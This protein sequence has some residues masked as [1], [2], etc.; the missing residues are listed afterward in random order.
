M[1]GSAL[2]WGHQVLRLPCFSE[3]PQWL[4]PA[5]RA[6]VPAG[7]WGVGGGFSFLHE[8]GMSQTGPLPSPLSPPSHSQARPLRWPLGPTHASCPTPFPRW[9][10][11]YPAG[12][13]TRGWP[14]PI[15]LGERHAGAHC[16]GWVQSHTQAG[17]SDPKGMPK[18]TGRTWGRRTATLGD[19]SRAGGGSLCHHTV[20]GGGPAHIPPHHG[21]ARCLP[22]VWGTACQPSPLWPLR[23]LRSSGLSADCG[24]QVA[25]GPL[26]GCPLV[27]GV[28]SSLDPAPPLPGMP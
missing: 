8:T 12:Q 21:T 14:G 25:P 26:P 19:S 27:L 11:R 6:S 20:P 13:A 3:K 4:G 7:L 10:P 15:G 17:Q 28:R 9:S 5:H 2:S 18:G 16:P 1:P 24:L 22:K 23:H